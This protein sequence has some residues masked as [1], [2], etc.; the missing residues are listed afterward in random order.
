MSHYFLLSRPFFEIWIAREL[1][2]GIPE[3][4]ST[5]SWSL[6]RVHFVRAGEK[7][8]FGIWYAKNQL[9][10]ACKVGFLD[11]LGLLDTLAS[12]MPRT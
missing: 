3:R 1:S 8:T 10:Q 2:D 5:M 11:P 4:F 12:G 7:S 6:T 9:C